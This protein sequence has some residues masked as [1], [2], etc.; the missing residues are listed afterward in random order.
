MVCAL[1]FTVNGQ[2]LLKSGDLSAVKVDQL[3]D[4]DI[5]KLQ[6]QLKSSGLTISQAE[7]MAAAKRMPQTEI[8]KLRERLTHTEAAN[9]ADPTVGVTNNVRTTS[10]LNEYKTVEKTA[11]AKVSVFGSQLFTTASLSFEPNL[12]IATP[13]NYVLGPDDELLLNIYGVQEASFHLLVQPEGMITIPQVGQVHVAGLSLEDAITQIKS[14]LSGTVYHSIKSG[15]THLSV[16]LGKIKSI[17]VTIL[18]AAKPGLYTIS[19]LTTLFNA[20][21]LAGGPDNN[22]GSYREITLI[23]GGKV[24]RTI[25][26]YEFL[27]MGYVKDN[28]LLKEGDVINIPVYK[29]RVTITGQIKRPGTYE[30]LENENTMR[31]IE[32]AG[33]FTEQAYTA[34]I[35]VTSLTATQRKVKDLANA[36]FAGYIPQK[37]DEFL[38]NGILDRYENRVQ[39]KGAVYR[40][41]QYELT[42]GLTISG[43]ITKSDGL[44]QDAFLERGL[45]TRTKDDMSIQNISFSVK[46]VVNGDTDIVLKRED[47]VQIASV[48]DLKDESV[49]TINGEVRKPGQFMYRENLG[50]KDLIFEAGGFTNAAANYRIEIARRIRNENGKTVSDSLA[51]ILNTGAEKDLVMRRFKYL[52]QPYDIVTVRRTPGY[53][54]QKKITIKGEVLYPGEYTIRLKTEKIGQLLLRSGGFTNAAYIDGIYLMRQSSNSPL[55]KKEKIDKAAAINTKGSDSILAEKI[56]NP[57]SKIPV[58]MR[59]IIA[60][61]YSPDNLILTEGDEIVV[62]KIN[63]LVKIT[64]EVYSPTEVKYQEGQSLRYYIDRAGGYNDFAR[65]TKTYV[66]YANGQVAKTKMALWGLIRSYPK[67]RTGTEIFVPKIVKTEHKR[68]STG[69]I[70]GLTSVIVSMAGVAVTLINSLNK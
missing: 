57:V 24:Y 25:D 28:V 61:P 45:L 1:F 14:K 48:F 41:G 46:D 4:A 52:L 38:V 59:A 56:A 65:R 9:R 49:V 39:I 22:I 47:I 34:S 29:K 20:L 12:R 42:S 50:L 13:M 33:G 32:C 15:S 53:A 8:I 21:Y 30:M 2:D 10:E 26:L 60:N 35:K 64:G 51:E 7:Q 16:T 23:R 67:I 62:P 66:V 31:L 19:S 54:E 6:Q 43:L 18:G 3:S 36:A 70:V 40:E 44:K 11:Q 37:G 5:A 27:M 63:E 68:L 69:E 58:N 55:E 17:R